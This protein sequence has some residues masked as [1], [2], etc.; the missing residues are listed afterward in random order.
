MNKILN[1]EGCDA[2][3]KISPI[4]IKKIENKSILQ[5]SNSQSSNYNYQSIEQSNVDIE[6]LNTN[7]DE[8]VSEFCNMLSIDKSEIKEIEEK[9]NGAIIVKLNNGEKYSFKTDENGILTNIY[10]FED[11]KSLIPEKY[12]T[13]TYDETCN[14]YTIN[15]TDYKTNQ[16]T[17]QTNFTG[18]IMYN[19]TVDKDGN[20]ISSGFDYSNYNHINA[21]INGDL[22]KLDGTDIETILGPDKIDEI[23]N[24]ITKAVSLCQT[25]GEKVAAAATILIASLAEEGY[26]MPYYL[27]G[28]HGNLTDGVDG[29]IGS[30][31]TVTG[32]QTQRN[33]K[34]YDCSGLINWAVRTALGCETGDWSYQG[35][36]DSNY[37]NNGTAISRNEATPGDVY[38]K[39]GHVFMVLDTYIDSNGVS[40]SIC[41]ESHCDGWVCDNS[42]QADDGIE[43]ID[44]ETDK[45][46]SNYNLY[47]MESYYDGLFN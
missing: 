17:T 31:T 47:D 33:I 8:E 46:T 29:T 23:N 15:T 2:M 41:A 10:Y 45:I 44:Y 25:N 35:G 11:E 24:E 9:G 21:T 38:R 42:A 34:S 22:K 30:V 6:T 43:I 26:Y 14:I 1:K 39:D 19:S 37:S 13:L 3:A 20:I 27:G 7:T 4:E 18:G 28:G 32:S 16:I 12:S 40:H 5:A 36:I